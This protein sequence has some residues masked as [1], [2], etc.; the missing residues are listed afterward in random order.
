MS[1]AG[2]IHEID[3]R[4]RTTYFAHAFHGDIQQDIIAI[5]GLK[6]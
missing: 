5:Y 2:L 1:R 4:Y 6:F 3:P